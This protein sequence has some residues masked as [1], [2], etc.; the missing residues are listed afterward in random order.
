MKRVIVDANV[1]AELVEEGRTPEGKLW[2][3]YIQKRKICLCHGGRL[4]R[5][6]AENA[7]FRRLLV[8]FARD[9]RARSF[10]DDHVDAE[11][12][13]LLRADVCESD[14]PHVLA[15]ARVS[16]ARV[17]FSRDKKLHSD[18][19]NKKIVPPPPGKIFQNCDHEHLLRD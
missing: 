2:L 3:N 16:T 6:L 17:L 9:G 10:P 11:V 14:D 4:S 1:C 18:F 5:E 7:R 8:A 19:T 12:E 15:V 13:F